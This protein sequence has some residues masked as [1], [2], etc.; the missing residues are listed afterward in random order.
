VSEDTRYFAWW[1]SETETERNMRVL[2]NWNLCESNAL[3]MGVAPEVFE[4]GEDD[5]LTLLTEEP[6][7]HLRT[8]VRQAAASCPKGA[9]T[10]LD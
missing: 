4:V 5:E 3:C 7:E 10:L 8:K 9:I 1:N 6:P 2:V